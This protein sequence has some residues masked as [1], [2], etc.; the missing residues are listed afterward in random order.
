VS[1][2]ITDIPETPVKNKGGRPKGSRS[3]PRANALMDRLA[4]AHAPEIKE[5]FENDGEAGQ[6]RRTLG[7]A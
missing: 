7:R 1:E 6:G 4:K 3:R 2:N 5:I